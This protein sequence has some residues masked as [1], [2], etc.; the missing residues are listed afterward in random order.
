MSIILIILSVLIITFLVLGSMFWNI[1][2]STS[3]LVAG[4]IVA[5]VSFFG[6]MILGLKKINN[7]HRRYEK[8]EIGMPEDEMLEIMGLQNDMIILEPHRKKYEWIQE[9]GLFY[10]KKI[11]IYVK[12]GK[13]EDI[14]S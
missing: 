1:D 13:V 4:Y 10:T 3:V 12:N 11:Y 5:L 2:I 7:H 6:G 9:S 14:L 8:V